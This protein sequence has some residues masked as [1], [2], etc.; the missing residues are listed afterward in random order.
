MAAD[1]K[2]EVQAMFDPEMIRA[3]FDRACDSDSER[4]RSVRPN[5]DKER[6]TDCGVCIEACPMATICADGTVIRIRYEGCI[7]CGIC[8]V[9]CRI[10]AIAME[11]NPRDSD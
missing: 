6:C 3:L 7:G 2:K 11:P 10:H 5:M 1:M 8:A 9:N 4:W